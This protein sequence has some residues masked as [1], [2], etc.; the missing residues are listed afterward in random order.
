MVDVEVHFRH[1]LMH[2][3]HLLARLREQVAAVPREIAQREDFLLRA[4]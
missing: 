2:E 3:L 1:H 4:E